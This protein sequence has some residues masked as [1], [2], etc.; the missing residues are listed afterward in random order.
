[1]YYEIK[2][3]GHLSEQWADWFDPLVVTNIENGEAVLTGELIDQA[4]LYGVLI[5]VRDMGLHLL[6]VHH[7]TGNQPGSAAWLDDQATE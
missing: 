1:M 5:R 7:T 6:D 2:V 3:K 4:A